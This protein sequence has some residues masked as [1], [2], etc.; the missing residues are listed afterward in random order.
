MNI[1]I[2]IPTYNRVVFLKKILINLIKFCPKNIKLEINICDS[3]SSDNTAYI[4]RLYSNK[5]K[6]ININY[7]NIKK[8]ILA[9]KRNYGILKSK[10]K[11]II[12]L[13]DDCI[14]KKNF[15]NEYVLEFKKN[16]DKII[17]CGIIEY[18]LRYLKKSPY[19]KFR[20]S[21][22]FKKV[23]EKNL[24]PRF[25]VAM[26]MGF[27]LNK[28]NKKILKF[29]ENF[30]GYGFEDYEFGYRVQ[31]QGFKLKKVNA[32][33]LHDEG[34]PDLA[35]FL[36]KHYHLG[37]DGMRNILKINK[38]AARNLIYY[39]IENNLFFRFIIALPFIRYFLLFFE[40]III[41]LEKI[42]FL[43]LNFFYQ[44]AKLCSYLRGFKD[45][46][47]VKNN[48]TSKNWYE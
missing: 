41:F 31:L 15:I 35:K 32:K 37:R 46:L 14:P 25:I 7:F 3:G 27:I 1:S 6:N 9:S 29:N 11:N 24:S 5:R 22:H 12:L 21:R 39:R 47:Q 23:D 17:L 36:I 38:S 28:K 16:N 44:M 20:N 10:Y 13:D 19:L 30:I 18:D 42:K 8:N 34:I 2:V 26:N 40:K 43:N 45:R 4:I 48:Q 33:I